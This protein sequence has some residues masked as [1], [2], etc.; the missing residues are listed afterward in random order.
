MLH[1]AQR[2]MHAHVP[3]DRGDKQLSD[4]V[5]YN[6]HSSMKAGVEQQPRVLGVT[7]FFPS[8]LLHRHSL[9]PEKVLSCCLYFPL[10]PM[11]LEGVQYASV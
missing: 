1:L 3:S 6:V 7:E 2:Y 9:L 11:L 10:L 4:E 8:P 5:L